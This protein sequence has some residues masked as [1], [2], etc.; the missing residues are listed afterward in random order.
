MSNL[1]PRSAGALSSIWRALALDVLV[2]LGFY[3]RLPLPPRVL[4]PGS[5]DMA[6]FGPASRVAPL[7][8]ALIGGVGAVCLIVAASLL[9]LPS[10]IAA[11]LA[12]ATVVLCSGG[13]H[14]DGLADIAD[15]FG[16][17]ASRER[18]LDIMRDSRIGT[19]G[20]LALV[21]SVLVRAGALTSLMER[22][23]PAGAAVILVAVG[24]AS[25]GFGL[26]PLAL[27][28]P[29]RTDGLA[30][31][32]G[33]LPRSAFLSAL[34]LATMLG[35]AGAALAGAGVL[36]ALLACAACGAAS[37][38]MTRLARD[39]IGGQTG[40]VSGAAQQLSE[41]AFLLALLVSPSL[42]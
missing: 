33:P 15:G 26:L 4:G 7:A 37:L 23:G 34:G 16:G 18:K 11:V 13:L 24:A 36:H 19:F 2:C 35:T 14:E 3:S 12:L 1:G 27:L 41:I 29:A 38:W 10:W 8:G 17:G 25:R 9:G 6:A 31:A 32:V 39:Q 30:R 5:G 42:G 40:D 22:Y 21:L 28:P 20:A